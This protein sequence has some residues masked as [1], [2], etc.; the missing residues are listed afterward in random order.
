MPQYRHM[1]HT[2]R[3]QLAT[4]VVIIRNRFENTKTRISYRA[5]VSMT[6]PL[7]T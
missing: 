3:H 4:L 5:A 6:A 1:T 7:V 2:V